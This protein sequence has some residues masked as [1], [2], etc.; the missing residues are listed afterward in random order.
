MDFLKDIQAKGA[1]PVKSIAIVNENTDYGTS[2]AKLVREAAAAAGFTIGLE[3][4]Y[5]AN[6]TDVS[7]QVL[8]LKQAN[9]DVV[10]F[11]SY[12]SDAILYMKTMQRLGYRAADADRRRFRASP[13]RPS[14]RASA[15][16]P[17][18]Q[19]TAAP[20]T[21][22]SRARP[23]YQHERD[24]Q[25][26]D[27][28]RPRRHPARAHA[29]LPGPGRAINRAGSTDPGRSRPRSK[30]TDLKPNQIL[31]GYQGVK[32]DEKGQNTLAT[33][34]LIQL[35]GDHYVAVWPNAK[36]AARTSAALQGLVS[37]RRS[38]PVA[39]PRT[40]QHVPSSLQVDRR[41]APARRGLRAVLLR[42]DA[43][44]GHD[45]RH[46]LRPWRLR[47]AGDVHGVLVWTAARRRPAAVRAGGGGGAV[48]ARRRSSIS[49]SS[50]TSCGGRCW[51]RSSAPSAWRCCCAIPR[52]GVRRQF[53]D[54]ARGLVGGTFDI[55]G[56]AS[57][58]RACSPGWWRCSSR[59]ACISS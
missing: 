39:G 32:F 27:R 20:G 12:T 43:D 26:E 5:S 52:S 34:L 11:V 8:Q 42:P 9:P 53:R 18:A 7:S 37:G 15:I 41:R 59:S 19:S 40:H 29:G 51:R 14:S 56:I 45:E 6:T 58:H 31:M 4:P 30:A 2:I 17:R 22:A 33:T 46:Q 57:T 1:N 24:V 48:R 3:I 54:A 28:Q 21:P 36:A 13:I 16:S 47:H 49:R 44:L 23:T 10:L 35:Q 50:G 55:L 25:G 38:A